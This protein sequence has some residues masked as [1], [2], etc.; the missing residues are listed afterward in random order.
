MSALG[1][2]RYPSKVGE[3]DVFGCGMKRNEGQEGHKKACRE[4]QHGWRRKAAALLAELSYNV[5]DLKRKTVLGKCAESRPST[6]PENKC[7]TVSQQEKREEKGR[8]E[9]EMREEEMT[10]KEI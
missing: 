9:K 7:E 10:K 5:P 3:F 8:E 1:R 6:A 2:V 4:L